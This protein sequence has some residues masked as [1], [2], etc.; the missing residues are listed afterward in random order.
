M[1]WSIDAS[2]ASFV[3][4][5]SA[6]GFAGVTV[7]TYNYQADLESW[8]AQILVLAESYNAELFELFSETTDQRL[9]GTGTAFI[10]YLA[11]YSTWYCVEHTKIMLVVTRTTSYNVTSVLCNE[12]ALEYADIEKAILFEHLEIDWWNRLPE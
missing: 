3:A 2:D 9:D 5:D 11:Q 1:D 8:V 6:D 10:I 12:A 7:E 4:F